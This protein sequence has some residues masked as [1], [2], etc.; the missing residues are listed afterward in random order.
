MDYHRFAQLTAEGKVAAQ[1]GELDVARR[2]AAVVVEPCLAYRDD[3][4]EVAVV[5]LQDVLGLGSEARMNTPL[6]PL[7]MN[8]SSR[9]KSL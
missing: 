6:L 7:V 2:K 3:A 1:V 8:S 4:L 5:P 9:M